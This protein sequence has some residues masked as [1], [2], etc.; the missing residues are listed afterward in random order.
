MKHIL[1]ILLVGSFIWYFGEGLLGP[2][3]AVF[4]QTIGGNILDITWAWAVYLIFAGIFSILVG[5]LADGLDRAKIMIA[6]YALN[7]VATF[8]YLWVNSPARLFVVQFV[9][10]LAL[11]LATPTWDGLYSLAE[12]KKKVCTE[13]GIAYGGPQIVLGV[14]AVLGGFIVS[15]WGFRALFGIMGS[16][17]I[18]ATLI[19][20]R[21]LFE[22][23]KA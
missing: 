16:V 5:K 2:L 12:D 20:A 17:Q 6:G 13:W 7:V 3:Y 22:K 9:L 19:Q 15:E 18:L 1:R 4:A 21:I 10:G 14:A 11:A 8:G 23:A